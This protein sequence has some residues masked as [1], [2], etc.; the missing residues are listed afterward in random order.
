MKAR[1]VPALTSRPLS[2]SWS[3]FSPRTV[4]WHAIFPFL[5]IPNVRTVSLAAATP[6]TQ[7]SRFL[8]ERRPGCVLPGHAGHA[9]EPALASQVR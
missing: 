1:L 8:T 9:S 7:A 6:N 2:S 3:A 4:T 5:R